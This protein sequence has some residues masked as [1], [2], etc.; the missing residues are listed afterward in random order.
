M[1]KYE[2]LP[3][4]KNIFEAREAA[5]QEVAAENEARLANCGRTWDGC[6]D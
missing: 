3:A 1:A 4:L 6:N 2:L 5:A